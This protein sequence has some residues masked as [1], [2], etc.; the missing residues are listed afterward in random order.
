MP[1]YS[2]T[3]EIPPNT[4]THTPSTTNNNLPPIQHVRA[5]C[6]PTDEYYGF[7]PLTG[8]AIT[9]PPDHHPTPL[10]IPGVT[11]AQSTES[12]YYTPGDMAHAIFIMPT[13]PITATAWFEHGEMCDSHHLITLHRNGLNR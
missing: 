10:C 4:H 13:R 3:F 6:Q 9:P 5:C 11:G 2:M 7:P 8:L 1:S 12:I